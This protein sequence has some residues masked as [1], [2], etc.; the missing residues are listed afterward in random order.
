MYLLGTEEAVDR[1]ESKET[2]GDGQNRRNSTESS[3]DDEG[4]MGGD[5]SRRSASEHVRRE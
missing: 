3:G 4:D 5:A 2:N 1:R